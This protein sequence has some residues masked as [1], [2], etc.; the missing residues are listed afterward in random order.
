MRGLGDAYV[1]EEFRRH[2]T[3]EARFLGNFF[4][5]WNGYLHSVAGLGSGASAPAADLG[6]HLDAT[7][8]ASMSEEQRAQLDLLRSETTAAVAASAGDIGSGGGGS[9]A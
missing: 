8:L 3:A 1:K 5:E 6:H 7:T 9:R 2:R 4:R